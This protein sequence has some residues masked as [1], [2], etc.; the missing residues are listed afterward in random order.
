M[1]PPA[2]KA[3]YDVFLS[4]SAKDRA[5][6]SR[7][8]SDLQLAG[9]A[10]WLDQWG[11]QGRDTIVRVIEQALGASRL[12]LVV[13]SPDYFQSQWTLQEWQYGMSREIDA[14]SVK[15]VPILYRDCEIPPMLRGEAVGRFS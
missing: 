3:A 13:M 1:E 15:L 2:Q 12:L 8:A 9:F 10:V 5:F 11:L 6:V 7:L 14:G 4:Y